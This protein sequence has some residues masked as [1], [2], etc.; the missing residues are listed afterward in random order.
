MKG[1]KIVCPMCKNEFTK[2]LPEDNKK[3]EIICPKCNKKLIV[4]NVTTEEKAKDE[5][6]WEEYGE[7][8]KTILSAIKPKTKKPLIAS[9]CLLI[10]GIIGILA[11]VIYAFTDNSSIFELNYLEEYLNAIGFN[12]WMIAVF[13]SVFSVFAI[14]VGLITFKRKFFILAEICAILSIFSTGLI[15]GHIIAIAALILIFLSRDEFE[16]ATKGRVF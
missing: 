3:Y 11:A 16:H 13:F 4:Q 15:V 9:I 14:I 6:S 2:D 8:R 5:F 1:R 7:P 12:D 10:V